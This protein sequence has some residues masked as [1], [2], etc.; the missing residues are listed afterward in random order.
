[1][2]VVVLVGCSQKPAP[3]PPEPEQPDPCI[4]LPQARATRDTLVVT[5]ADTVDVSHAPIPT[6]RSERLLFRE[7]YPTLVRVDCEGNVRPGLAVS[8]TAD[9]VR[10]TWTFALKDKAL[11]WDSR[12]EAASQV[13][14]S[15]RERLPALRQAGIAAETA[16][17]DGSLTVTMR[18]ALDSVPRIFGDPALAVSP[19]SDPRPW[20]IDAGLSAGKHPSLI[21]YR[22]APDVDPR[23]AL[24][25][26]TDLLVT[27]DPA[28]LEYASGKP[29]F[30]ALPLMWSRTYI[31]VQP[32]GAPPLRPSAGS[33]AVRAEARPAQ[34]PFWW[35]DSSRCAPAPIQVA[36]P[37]SSRVVYVRGDRVARGLAERIVALA[38]DRTDLR[39]ASLGATEFANSLS[40]GSDAAYIL[41]V[42]RQSLA[43]C[44]ESAGWPGGATLH[45]LVDVRDYAIVREGSPSLTV[46]WDGTIRVRQV[47]TESE[48]RQ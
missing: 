41:A 13:L 36:G 48:G 29:G 25:R 31:L 28:L 21:T 12:S 32:S 26:G 20:R 8:W 38:S 24:D 46:D 30:S 22:V 37:A 7:F 3:T 43:P 11:S 18:D 6:N 40:S 9:S 16:Q 33:D 23:D 10:R 15:W 14:L 4:L 2:L 1:V 47:L 19:G 45:A 44:R 35:D 5:L 42:P 27:D 39:A 34:P 17:P